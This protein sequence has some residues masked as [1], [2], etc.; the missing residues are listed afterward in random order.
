MDSEKNPEQDPEKEAG[1]E[2]EQDALHEVVSAIA[3]GR[4][5]DWALI[6][7]RF[8]PAGRGLIEQ[9]HL[10]AGIAGAF[11]DDTPATP[12]YPDRPNGGA[13]APAAGGNLG[14]PND[15]APGD[16]DLG[17]WGDL[18]L[19]E[20]VGQGSFGAVYRAHDPALDR[21]VAVKLLHGTSSTDDELETRLR[22]EGQT[23]A[24]LNHPNVVRIFGAAKHDGRV[25]LWM[26]FVR[27]LTLEQ[28]LVNHGQFSAGE[29]ALV[30][31]ELCDALTA[32]HHADLIHRDVKAQNVMREV[33]GRL[34]LMDFGAG[35]RR[36]GPAIGGRIVGTPLYLA[37]EVIRGGEA[38]VQSDIYSLG[39]LLYHLVTNEFPVRAATFDELVRAYARGDIT[40][41]QEARPH[42]PSSF[43]RVI[44]RAINPSPSKRFASANRMGAALA[45]VRG[46]GGKTTAPRIRTAGRRTPVGA[47]GPEPD[48]GPSVAVLP[49]ADMSPA[50][51]QECFCDG[52]TE[53]IISALAQIPGLR[54]AARTSTFRFKT[55][56]LDVRQIG[57]SLNVATVLDGSV[58]KDGDWLRIT[59]E[60]IGSADGYH[61]WSERFDRRLVDVFAVQGEIAGA[62]ASTLKG[63]LA[64]GRPGAAARSSDVEAYALYLEG[65]Y[66]WNKRNE[67]ELKKSVACFERSIE[68]DPT[69]APAHAGLAD[70]CVMLG[71]YGAMPPDEVMPR[72]KSAVDTAL[73][74]DAGLAEAYA[75]RACISAVYDWSWSEAER[76]F[77]RAI[78][79]KPSYPTAH[80]WY[81]INYLVVLRRFDEAA[82]A[83]R[84]ALDLDP[85]GLA[86]RTSVGM[87]HYFAGRYKDA[88][89]EL[90]STVELDGSFGMAHF[91]L[92]A[93]ATEMRRYDQA[94]RELDTAL[95]L[96][97]RS[98]EILA[99]VGY[100]HGVSG[101]TAEARD[102]M[103]ELRRIAGERYVS[104][105]RIAQVHIGLGERA[106][107]L[108][109]L[110]EAHAGRAADLAWLGVRPVF[111]SLRAEPRFT[112]LLAKMGI[113]P[114]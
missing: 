81:A 73:H 9:L 7:Q 2:P 79:L 78:A 100:L 40:P 14:P 103:G 20:E 67:G 84:R 23:M 25:G 76:D 82:D 4:E 99:A 72:A 69:F 106:A 88:V 35:R 13:P 75:C 47:A 65:R 91:F 33:G 50:K 89:R 66:H 71:T 6:E 114:A 96:S 108:D 87:T 111:A 19:I 101:Q 52:I 60:L 97:G 51:D 104:P 55:H 44:E 94:A 57:E 1:N 16:G 22:H 54:V 90:S 36:S 86:V 102:V 64:A 18:I 26:E 17:R 37:P 41:L 62:V 85:L 107:A 63:R 92:G 109:R 8:D 30:G 15:G 38:T 48:P 53:E 31:C 70:A 98:P 27:G 21:P 95:R 83:L 34:V 61:L 49:F 56:A 58:R 46:S 59:V 68:R 28:M 112:Q 45:Q 24:R 93:A 3:D 74:L 32:V 5:I 29:A 77:Q 43:V 12:D 10:I 80:H 113:P 39:V 110:E 42:L 11:K 105:A